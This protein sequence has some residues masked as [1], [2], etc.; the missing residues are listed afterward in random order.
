ML[1]HLLDPG[2]IL[3]PSDARRDGDQMLCPHDP[4][5]Y[6]LKLNGPGFPHRL[7]DQAGGLE[8]L[9]RKVPTDGVR[10]LDRVFSVVCKNLAHFS[11]AGLQSVTLPSRLAG[12]SHH[13][14]P[15]QQ[16]EQHRALSFHLDNP[17]LLKGVAILQELMRFG[18]DLDPARQSMRF[19]ARSGID[20]VAPKIVGEFLE[21]DH[22]GDGRAR[23][24]ANAQVQRLAPRVTRSST[25]RT[26]SRAMS[27]TASAFP[28]LG[29][30]IP[31]ATM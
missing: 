4:S 21:P 25:T 14:S 9:Y 29:T 11:R 2:T 16:K 6:A 13:L 20:R 3:K 24:D 1:P 5:C 27:A 7:L 26:I 22:A 12:F 28:A 18:R 30:G 23:V 31:P 15:E 17:P 8:P 19:H 10:V